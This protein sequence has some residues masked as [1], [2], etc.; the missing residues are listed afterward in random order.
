MM[1]PLAPTVAVS[2]WFGQVAMASFWGGDAKQATTQTVASAASRLADTSGKREIAPLKRWV[3]QAPHQPTLH[4]LIAKLRRYFKH[5]NT[6]TPNTKK[7]SRSP[8]F[9]F[10]KQLS[11]IIS[12]C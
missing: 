8:P 5:L 7:V 10:K 4:H 1:S 9:H 3:S 6:Q 11:K 2:C 12:N